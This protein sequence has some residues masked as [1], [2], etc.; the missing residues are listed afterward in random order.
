MVVLIGC[1]LWGIAII[2]SGVIFRRLSLKEK[3]KYL[4]SMMFAHM[5]IIASALTLLTYK[6]ARP[7]SLAL[8]WFWC[9]QFAYLMGK[10]IRFCENC[11]AT[12]TGTSAEGKFCA[13][14]GSRLYEK[15]L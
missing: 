9:L 13:Q 8:I 1:V 6:E 12:Q 2:F 5:V 7:Y 14:C 11:G 3:R 10:F 4:P 15:Q